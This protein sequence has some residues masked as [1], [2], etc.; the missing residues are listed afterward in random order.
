MSIKVRIDRLWDRIFSFKV[1][2]TAGED[3]LRIPVVFESANGTQVSIEERK[4]SPTGNA[5][6]VQIGP[7]DIISNIPVV[8]DYDHHQIHEGETFRWSVYVS[9]L[10]SGNNKDIRFVVPNITI[11]AGTSAVARCPHFRFEVVS[12]DLCQIFLYEIPTFTG[13]GSQRTPI[14]MERNGSYTSKLQVWEDPTISVVGTQLFQGLLLT[15]KNNAGALGGSF[16]EFI[17]KNNTEYA[18]RATSGAAG[19]KV[20]MRFVWYEDLGT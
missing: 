9:S 4:Q 5:M 11:P 13:N 1:D 10:A 19:N 14:A 18:F 17:L 12:S 7:S 8:L 15:T 3:Q 16:D 20:L 2:D 6:N